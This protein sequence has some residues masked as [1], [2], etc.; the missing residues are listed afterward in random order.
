MDTLKKYHNDSIVKVDG[1][2]GIVCFI[3][4]IFGP[5]YGTALAGILTGGEAVKT[6]IITMLLM[7]VLCF[8][9]VGWIWSIYHGYLIYQKSK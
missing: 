5:G 3:L 6:G 2:L 9:F 8:I 1:G 7:W 4:N